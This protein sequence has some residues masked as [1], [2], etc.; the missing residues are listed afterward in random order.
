MDA[1][2]VWIAVRARAGSVEEDCREVR[3]GPGTGWRR[4]T[5]I[6]AGAG[7]KDRPE[8]R[9][10]GAGLGRQGSGRG[11]KGR[12]PQGGEVASAGRRPRP[13]PH[14]RTNRAPVSSAASDLRPG[15]SC[16]APRPPVLQGPRGPSRRRPGPR[17]GA[18]SQERD[19]PSP[20]HAARG[21]RAGHAL[22]RAGLLGARRET[23]RG[24][25]VDDGPPAAGRTETRTGREAPRRAPAALV[26]PRTLGPSPPLPAHPR[27]C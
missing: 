25:L 18:P 5:R 20:P 7:R 13:R 27:A 24:D 1:A 26:S 16:R 9:G 14:P 3:R 23:R 15:P 22:P 17:S 21:R 11:A 10:D 19:S 6:G 2:G 8:R 4:G 12:R